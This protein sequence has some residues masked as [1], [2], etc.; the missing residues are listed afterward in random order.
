[1]SSGIRSTVKGRHPLARV[2]IRK[3][4]NQLIKIELLPPDAS[5]QASPA[6]FFDS[7]EPLEADLL[8]NGASHEGVLHAKS[9]LQSGDSSVLVRIPQSQRRHGD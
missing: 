6:A 2:M 1:M 8:A 5:V 7:W 9:M 3:A 4:G